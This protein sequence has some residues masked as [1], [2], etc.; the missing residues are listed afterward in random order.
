MAAAG[1]AAALVAAAGTAAAVLGAAGFAAAELAAGGLA[2]TFADAVGHP[3]D[4]CCSVTV[5]VTGAWVC[6]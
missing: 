3:P 1:T 6:T 5:T 2:G 4:A